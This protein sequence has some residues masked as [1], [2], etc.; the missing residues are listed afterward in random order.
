MFTKLHHHC[1]KIFLLSL[2]SLTVA[3]VAL[4]DAA[5]IYYWEPYPRIFI[6]FTVA[7]IMLFAVGCV[8]LIHRVLTA[9]ER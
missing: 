3:I 4:L 8:V 1:G 6:I 5:P 9:I 2:L 7:S